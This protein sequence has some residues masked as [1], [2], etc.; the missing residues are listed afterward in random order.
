MELGQFYRSNAGSI[1]YLWDIFKK[2]KKKRNVVM[3]WATGTLHC[4]VWS[5]SDAF[6]I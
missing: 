3:D 6:L 4:V 2:G 1:Y 5:E